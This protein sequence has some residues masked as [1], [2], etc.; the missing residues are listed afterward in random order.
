M[1][2][3]FRSSPA[4]WRTRPSEVL[5]APTLGDCTLPGSEP[6]INVLMGPT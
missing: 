4:A 1:P 5:L 3:A 6:D 2:S